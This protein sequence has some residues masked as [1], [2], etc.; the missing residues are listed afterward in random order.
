MAIQKGTGFTNLNRILQAN[1]GNKLGQTVA[2]GIQGQTQGVTTQVKSAQD[3]FQEEAQKNRLDTDDAANKRQSILDR[4]APSSGST[5]QAPQTAKANLPQEQTGTPNFAKTSGTAQT[6]QAAGS[7]VSDQEI[8][9]FTKFRTGTYTGPKELQDSTSLYGK[10]QQAEALGGLSKSE[11]GRQEL[12]RRFVGGNN[13]TS[14][15]KQLDS[16][17]LGQQPGQLNQAARDARGATN[18][19]TTANQQASNLAQEYTNRAKQ[20]GQDTVQK[21]GEVKNPLSQAVDTKVSQAQTAEQARQANLKSMQD[22]LAGS[23]PAYKGLDQWTRSGLA[24]QD[25]AN[26]GVLSQNDVDM[27]M[28][29]GDKIGLLQ[30]GANL[31]LDMSQMIRE[32]LSDTAAQNLSRTGLAGDEDVAKLNALDRLAG[33]GGSDLEFLDSRGKFQAGKTGFNTGSLDDYISKTEKERAASD[34]A[35]A[36]KLAQE[37]ARYLTQAQ[38]GIGQALGGAMGVGGTALGAVMDPT[39][40]LRPG[41]SASGM[42]QGV[43]DMGLGQA[44]AYSQGSNSILEGLTKLNV[45]GKSLA[46]TEGGKQLLKAIELKSKLENEALGIGGKAVGSVAGGLTDLS[47]GN[48][49]DAYKA[50]SGIDIATQVGGQVSQNVQNELKEA[51]KKA[52]AKAVTDAAGK[53]VGNVGKA[54]GNAVS[55]VGKSV[56]GAVKSVTCFAGSTQILME[57]GEYKNVKDLKLGDITALGGMVITAGQSYGYDMYDY[58]G[59]QV[60]GTHAVFEDGQWIRVEDSK[61]SNYLDKQEIVYPIATENHLM[62]TN[63]QIWADIFEIDGSQG[64]TYE[65]I[66]DILNDDSERNEK[67][68]AFEKEQWK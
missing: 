25:A 68:L 34:K 17:I 33:K 9:D 40:I 45:G 10:A 50:L 60:T 20:F 6:T 66:I 48:V 52:N 54:A 59:V 12:L 43:G 63:G 21:L 35:Y 16:T 28:G 27:L 14:G 38:A 47:K 41:E 26:R 44:R 61:V 5:P 57:N 1:K 53:A 2:G 11:G 19:V 4:F 32:R 37:Q 24:L 30:R 22:L 7:P 3:Q 58:N 62:V 18:L 55:S 56:G 46:D 49:L 42:V 65:Q 39:S 8:Q 23:D 29:S 15:Q 13:Y 31:G 67:L 64:K 51:I 36:D